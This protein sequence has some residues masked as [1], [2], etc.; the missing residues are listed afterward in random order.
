MLVSEPSPA[1][2]RVEAAV[3]SDAPL[4]T[5]DDGDDVGVSR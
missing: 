3:F 5:G 2:T 4:Y 1:R